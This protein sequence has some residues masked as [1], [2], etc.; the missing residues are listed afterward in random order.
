[1]KIQ[2]IQDAV[3]MSLPRT[4]FEGS[5][6]NWG[7][8]GLRPFGEI[9][10][11]GGL[12][13]LQIVETRPSFRTIKTLIFER[14]GGCTC[15]ACMR[16]F[17]KEVWSTFTLAM[18]YMQFYS[19][20]FGVRITWSLE[21]LKSYEQLIGLPLLPNVYGPGGDGLPGSMCLGGSI[22][23]KDASE[24]CHLFWNTVFTPN[25][26]KWYYQGDHIIAGPQGNR[27]KGTVLE[28]TTLKSF[29]HWHEISKKANDPMEVF[30]GFVLPHQFAYSQLKSRWTPPDRATIN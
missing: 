2:D 8:N 24:V 22:K 16:K 29:A 23:I 3:R 14:G 28:N 6:A 19:A 7:P 27:I 11:S 18:P 13:Q 4:V 20:S 30:D 26:D 12:G 10:S 9:C 15:G 1:M 25:D 21:P 5:D 17:G